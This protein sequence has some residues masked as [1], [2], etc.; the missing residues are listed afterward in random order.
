M[1]NAKL[2]MIVLV[3]LAQMWAPWIGSQKMRLLAFPLS[4]PNLRLH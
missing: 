1:K 2:V 4:L 3:L